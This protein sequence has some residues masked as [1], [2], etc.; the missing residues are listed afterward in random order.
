MEASSSRV[1]ARVKTAPRPQ[2][3]RAFSSRA[4]T[5][6]VAASR[7]L[8]PVRRRA[9]VVVRRVERAVR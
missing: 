4:L 3:K 9:W 8:V 2:L 7:A 5:A 6:R 1:P